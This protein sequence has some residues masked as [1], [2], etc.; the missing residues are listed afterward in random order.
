M[1]QHSRD[2]IK[3]FVITSCHELSRRDNIALLHQHLPGLLEMEAVYP[4]Y[5]RV[6]FLHQLKQ[7]SKER[8][9]KA[10]SD[11][12]I[13]ILLSNRKIWKHICSIAAN[14][15]EHFLIMESDSKI[16]DVSLLQEQGKKLA[17]QYDLFFHGGWMGNMKLKRSTLQKV[18]ETF[19]VGEPYR[20]TICSG[21]GYSLNRVAAKYLLK[22]TAQIQYPVDEF[23]KYTQPGVLK[24]GAILPELISEQPGTSTI[25]HQQR[26]LFL[27][28]LKMRLVHLRNSL[29]AYCS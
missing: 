26:F 24:I 29:I 2:T 8:T 5:Q 12:E 15:Q 11:G 1:M 27:H 18:N 17:E 23:K 3:A 22:C 13:G 19:T 28:T 6:P 16:N 20:K 21:Y 9:G 7:K 4:R 14:D 25:G 10:L